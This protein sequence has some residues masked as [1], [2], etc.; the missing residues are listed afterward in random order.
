MDYTPGS[1]EH[2]LHT[3]RGKVNASGQHHRNKRGLARLER[4]TPLFFEK[5]QFR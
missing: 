5:R 2:L 4:A 1:G 3:V